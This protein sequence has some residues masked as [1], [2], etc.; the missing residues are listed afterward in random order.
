MS[1]LQLFAQVTVLWNG[2][3]PNSCNWLV[4][5]RRDRR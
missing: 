1:M 4:A 2:S 5:R 3:S